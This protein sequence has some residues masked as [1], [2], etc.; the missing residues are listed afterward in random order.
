[1]AT[2]KF[3]VQSKKDNAPVYCRLSINKQ[4]SFKRKTGITANDSILKRVS[5][6]RT[7]LDESEK[8]VKSQ[9]EGLRLGLLDQLNSLNAEGGLIDGYWLDNAIS[10]YF[11]RDKTGKSD[12]LTDYTSKFIQNLEFKISERNGVV[13]SVSSKKKYTSIHKKLVNFEKFSNRRFR[14]SE[15]DLNFRKDFL[16]YLT[17]VDGISRNTAGRHIKFVKTFVLDAKKNGFEIS[18]QMSEFRGFTEKSFKVLLSFDE[19]EVLRNTSFENPSLESAKD[20]LIVGCY[21]GQ[22]VSD[23]LRMNSSMIQ[24]V[25]GFEL[26]QIT[27]KKT[28]KTVQI[29]V[30]PIVREILDKR[31]AEFP[32]VLGS[33]SD[34]KSAI[35]NRQIKEVCRLVGFNSLEDG[36]VYSTEDKRN[37]YGQYE[38][39]QLVTSHICRRSFATNFYSNQKY[40]TPLLMNITAHSTEKMFL[41]YIGKPPLDYS[42]QLAQIWANEALSSSKQP[43]LK[44]VPF[45]KASG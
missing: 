23:L 38:K 5:S 28:G 13:A 7:S 44:V 24:S 15:V 29:P 11:G 3:L 36:K 34:S 37:V 16:I 14:I 40:P 20:W 39:W 32:K 22:R 2:I 6:Q 10:T 25:K 41:E 35:F 31:N 42:L 43:Q 30:H 12:L 8:R 4:T 9:L 17:E 19:I 26:L 27:Q 18:N 21:T 45:S 1:M 33:T